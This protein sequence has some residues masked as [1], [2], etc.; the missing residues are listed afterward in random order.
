MELA[1][2]QYFQLFD[3]APIG[4]FV[5]GATGEILQVNA[6]GCEQLGADRKKLL[7]RRFNGFI[8]RECQDGFHRC[9]SL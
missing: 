7:G 4:Y 3:H 2:E 9:L 5:L 6:A 1:Q 8:T